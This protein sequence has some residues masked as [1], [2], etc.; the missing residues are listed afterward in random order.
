MQTLVRRLVFGWLLVAALLP[1][2]AGS[3]E[4]M[5]GKIRVGECELGVEVN[6]RWHTLRLRARNPSLGACFIDRE[7]MLA[8]LSSAFSEIGSGG[9]SG[10]YTSLSIG[11]MIDY[12]WIS[13]YLAETAH[14]DRAWNAGRGKPRSMDVNR[15]VAGLLSGPEIAGPVGAALARGGYRVVGVT[16]EKVLVGKIGE[17]PLYD[18]PALRGR[19]PYDAQVWFR[20]EKDGDVPERTSRVREG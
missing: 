5:L 7:S 19:V 3:Q 17:V 16:V 2:T 11:R 13:R 20:I 9:A 15:Y 4:P 8:A 1:S 10:A 18:G 12:P 14:R 6:D